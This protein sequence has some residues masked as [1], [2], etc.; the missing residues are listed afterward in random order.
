MTT[1]TDAKQLEAGR[2]L[3]IRLLEEAHATEAALVTT[4]SAHISMTPRGG[5]RE[6]LEVH[7]GETRQHARAIENRLSELGAHQSPVDAAATLAKTLVGQV[8]SLAKGPVDLLRGS[9]GE[10]KLLKNA[11]DESATEALEIALYD[12]LETAALA[13]GDERTARLART[14]RGQEERMLAG[15]RR[16]IPALTAATLVAEAGGRPRHDPAPEPARRAGDLPIAGYEALNAN[17]VIPRLARLSP[18][19]LLALEAHERAN[20]DRRTILARIAELQ[21]DE[22]LAAR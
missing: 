11:R 9:G 4:L 16:A 3:V 17:Q 12:A 6:L 8:L 18:A 13:L 15:L 1:I 2:A 19:D 7:L 22:T 21:A 20:R 10:E 14:H 5:Y